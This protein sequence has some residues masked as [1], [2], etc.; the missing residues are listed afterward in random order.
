MFGLLWGVLA[1]SDDVDYVYEPGNEPSTEA[2]DEDGDGFFA[3]YSTSD[4]ARADCDDADPS[5]TPFEERY[6][7]AGYFWRGDDDAPLAGPMR[8]IFLSDY[9]LD[10][11]EVDNDAF[12]AFME[13][14][15]GD[16]Y[17][18]DDSQGRP[19]YD[20]DDDDDIYGPTILD[21]E[22][23]YVAVEGRGDHPVTEVWHWSGEAFCSFWGKGLPT[24]AQWEKGARGTDRRRY[25][26]GDEDP[27]CDKANHGNPQQRCVG[28]TLCRQFHHDEHVDGN[29]NRNRTQRCGGLDGSP[30]Q[31]VVGSRC[32]SRF[33]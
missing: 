4:I 3:W 30:T 7:P 24:E 19:L 5:V 12:A 9:C 14:M 22:N 2:I 33:D 1:C 23:G 15:R 31:P 13:E 16:G 20:F 27:D 6:V 17:V 21:S 18:N 11:F 29:D 8:E 26:W 28:D 32:E 10:R 25:P